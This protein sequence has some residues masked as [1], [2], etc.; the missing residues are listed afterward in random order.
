M[1]FKSDSDS[2]IINDMF[3]EDD[4]SDDEYNEDEHIIVME[5]QTLLKDFNLYPSTK[6]HLDDNEDSRIQ[7]L[8]FMGINH[9]NWL[10]VLL[11]KK[12]LNI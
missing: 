3:N 2:N 7:Y 10:K 8:N 5:N 12:Y 11:L 1:W 4:C 9:M 6:Y